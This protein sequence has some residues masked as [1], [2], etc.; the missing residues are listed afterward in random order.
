MIWADFALCNPE[1]IDQLDRRL[2][3][4]DWWYEATFDADRIRGLRRKGFEVWGCP[5]TSSWNCLFPRTENAE[6]NVARWADAGRRHGAKG[7]LNTDWGDFGHY[8][9]LGVSL[10][11]Y[12][13][14]AQHAWSGA[15]DPKRF[16]RA[17]DREVFGQPPRN[18]GRIARL[19]RKLGQIHDAGFQIFN[20]SALQYLYFDP[21]ARSF[22]LSHAESK[23]L[24]RSLKRLEPLRAEIEAWKIEDEGDDFVRLSLLEVRWAA[25][26]TQLAAQ[27]G[28]FA[29]E[30]NRWRAAPS[31][32]RASDRRRLAAAADRLATTQ[33]EQLRELES[34]WMARNAVSD[35]ALTQ[36]RIRRSARGLARA[37]AQLRLNTPP[38]PARRHELTMNAV[39]NEVRGATL[40]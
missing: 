17:F 12:A 6:A 4:L 21:I 3:L 11:G 5:G 39:Y 28:L 22:F 20:G 16:D 24:K 9:A 36:R 8:N 23:A 34:L 25:E 33:T 1:H 10:Q 19:F 40:R 27:K 2:V 37:A 14:G 29:I 13:I 31:S 30:F 26:A 32:L 38:K 7:M 18:R 15:P 35:F